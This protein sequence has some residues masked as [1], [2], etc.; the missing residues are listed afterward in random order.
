MKIL[1]GVKT[2][3]DTVNVK[4][5]NRNLFSKSEKIP[6]IRSAVFMSSKIRCS[7]YV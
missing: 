1:L 4:A 7:P 2:S 6:H 3:S 5:R